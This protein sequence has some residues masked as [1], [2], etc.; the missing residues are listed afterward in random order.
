MDN[1]SNI[2]ETSL[3]QSINND[4]IEKIDMIINHPSFDGE[5][6][7]IYK[8]F[9]IVIKSNHILIFKK[10]LEVVNINIAYGKNSLLELA[11]IYLN[12]EFIKII[13]NHPN[14]DPNNKQIVYSFVKTF[15]QFDKSSAN[16]NLVIEVMNLIL[17]F[18]KQHANLINFKELLEN[19]Q[20]F[21]TVFFHDFK[22]IDKVS[23]FLLDQGVDPNAPDKFNQYPLE[24]AI[25][26]NSLNFVN[27]LLNS[28]KIN[29]QQKIKEETYLHIAAKLS[30]SNILKVLLDRNE[31][32]INSINGKGETPLFYACKQSNIDCVKMLFEKDELD[33]L[34]KDNKGRD[35]L[36]T[37]AHLTKA[38]YN[39]S[40]QS[41]EK[42]KQ[43]IIS[44]LNYENNYE[45]ESYYE[46]STESSSESEEDDE[47]NAD[48]YDRLFFMPDPFS[49]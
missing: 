21:F 29:L 40:I 9:K 10:L 32:D 39:R 16:E 13:L 42:Y 35:V 12:V 25:K 48:G 46:S 5:K 6:S 11:S 38:E 15:N 7:H 47:N 49:M 28:N 45:E 14:F 4:N 44:I 43:K 41:K 36:K 2:D 8:A 34:H 33:Y 3:I 27:S 20:S 37:I 17:D 30:D 26:L 31:I 1:Y 24:N 22:F 19:G 23:G 18:D